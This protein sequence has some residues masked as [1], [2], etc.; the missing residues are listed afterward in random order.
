MSRKTPRQSPTAASKEPQLRIPKTFSLGGATW[1][2]WH[3]GLDADN[4]GECDAFTKLI[5]LHPELPPRALARTFIH[6]VLHA[7]W[8]VGMTTDEQEDAII[9]KL[10]VPLLEAILS[11]AFRLEGE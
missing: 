2:V 4:Y 8:P 10:E 1:E 7:A 5:H 3:G 9:S 11:G 6:E